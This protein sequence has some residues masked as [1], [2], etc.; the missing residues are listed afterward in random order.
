MTGPGSDGF[1]LG[2]GGRGGLAGGGGNG[3]VRSRFGWYAAEVQRTI[4]EALGRNRLTSRAQ[5][6]NKVRIWTDMTGRVTRVKLEGSTGD[7]AVDRAIGEAL[8]GLQ[9]QDP[10]PKD[11]PMPIVMRLAAHRPG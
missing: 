1:G 6:E 9:L 5:F 2:A 11:M 4:Q 8:A 3:R 7:P 10:P